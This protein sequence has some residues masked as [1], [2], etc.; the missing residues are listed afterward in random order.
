MVVAGGGARHCDLALLLALA[1]ALA[2]ALILALPLPLLLP[3]TR[4]RWWVGG[5]LSK[6]MHLAGCRAKPRAYAYA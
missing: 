3:L 1:Y 6:D 5:N 4:R 2:P